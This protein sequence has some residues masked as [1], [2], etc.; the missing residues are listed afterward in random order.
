MM[1]LTLTLFLSFSLIL[2]LFLPFVFYIVR[3]KSCRHKWSERGFIFHMNPSPYSFFFFLFTRLFFSYSIS[4][5]FSRFV[6]FLL[7][8]TI[9]TTGRR[10][11]KSFLLFRLKS[12]FLFFLL[13]VYVSIQ[14][15]GSLKKKA[16][17]LIHLL[18]HPKKHF[19]SPKNKRG[20]IRNKNYFHVNR[21]IDC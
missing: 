15:A 2:F 20:K 9:Y 19:H 10:N 18:I 1:L 13:S 17:L 8:F 6:V 3:W 12:S 11:I 7:F 21:L 4:H 14:C 16:F 5:I